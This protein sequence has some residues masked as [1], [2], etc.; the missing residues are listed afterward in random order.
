[1]TYPFCIIQKSNKRNTFK[2]TYQILKEIAEV[3]D[4]LTDQKQSRVSELLG[5]KLGLNVVQS[6]LGNF[7]T[8]KQIVEELDEGLAD[9]SASKELEKSLDS[10]QAKLNQLKSTWQQF[11][12]D[13]LDTG[14]VKGFVDALKGLVSAL[15]TVVKVA[16]KY[17][18]AAK[19]FGAGIFANFISKKQTGGLLFGGANGGVLGRTFLPGIQSQ[20]LMDYTQLTQQLGRA[21]IA[22]KQ[23][24]NLDELTGINQQLK[25]YVKNTD[26]ASVSVAGFYASQTKS[27]KGFLGSI[28]AIRTYNSISSNNIIQRK[29]F[30]KAVA[31]SNKQ[32]GQE[33]QNLNGANAGLST[34]TSSLGGLV[35][36]QAAAT[37]GAIAFNLAISA[38]IGLAIQGI[39]KLAHRYEEMQEKNAE[40]IKSFKETSDTLEEERNNIEDLLSQY[41]NILVT[42]S[43]LSSAQNQLIEIQENLTDA[44][45]GEIEGLD[46]L[47]NSFAE[48]IALIQKKRREDA[49]S[50]IQNKKNENDYNEAKKLLDEVAIAHWE[51]SLNG[52]ILRKQGNYTEITATGWGDWDDDKAASKIING[53]KNVDYSQYRNKLYVEGTIEQQLET[54]NGIYKQLS[55]LWGDKELD[56]NQRAWLKL[57]HD[58]INELNNAIEESKRIISEWEIKQAIADSTD[59]SPETIRNIDKIKEAIA[60][61]QQA[62]TSSDIITASEQYQALK[63]SIYAAIPEEDEETRGLVD[64]YFEEIEKNIDQSI[65]NIRDKGKVYEQ[66]LKK[67]QDETYSA[68]SDGITKI[69]N[70]L[71]TVSLG[72][73]IDS[74]TLL[75]LAKNDS[76]L[77]GEF[78]KTADGYTLSIEALNKARKKLIEE[79][80][81]DVEDEIESNKKFIEDQKSL[82]EFYTKYDT[83]GFLIN[84]KER[85]QAEED[86]KDAEERLAYWEAYLDLIT[87]ATDA[88]SMFQQ[89]MSDIKG[90]KDN[91]TALYSDEGI[92]D[93]FFI[94]HPE[95][96]QYKDDVEAL[97]DE[98]EKIAHTNTSPVI[99]QLQQAIK[100]A[101]DVGD[102]ESVIRYTSMLEQLTSESEFGNL[103]TLEAQKKELREQIKQKEL[104]IKGL[105]RQK[106]KEEK[107]LDSLNKQKE[108][109]E[110]IA[111]DYETAAKTAQDYIDDQIEALDKEIDKLEEHKKAI[112]DDFDA[113]I[114]AI[115]DAIDAIEKE[116]DALEK[117][118]EMQER[119]NDL[120]EKE[121]ALEK[122]RNQKVRVYTAEKGWVSK[123]ALQYS[124][125]LINK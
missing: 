28:Q 75:E 29:K 33:L 46:L 18:A 13:S 3:Y 108:A 52:Q 76:S 40:L 43:D 10:I 78:T 27:A 81:A 102:L 85:E 57:I 82:I 87:Q 68:F 60:L 123:I 39:S 111:S 11:S 62:N 53:Y 17:S 116:S 100:E 125:V 69:D 79:Q 89:A 120:K 16:N 41:S 83:N 59:L 93:Q 22:K 56:A 71:K 45:G 90:Y 98:I 105:E 8:A 64:S 65:L 112:E 61:L 121:L 9:N 77:L 36:K 55:E 92:G 66:T 104:Y 7:E 99:E 24:A 119:L 14:T 110:S 122:A 54:L 35:I 32:L 49:K 86:K 34:Y 12:T 70:A 88:T 15:D 72:G 106:S 117:E 73:S 58:R 113:R 42:T 114:Q 44:L 124:N 96:L 31:I 48:N 47:N 2:S 101:Q 4:T 20:S 118:A 109:L 38:A 30:A 94:D 37:A 97:A 26:D 74:S 63:D 91:I 19:V 95:L 80:K 21:M 107:I 23:G 50:Y 103:R 5:G 1:M 67:F 25:E 51:Q 6:I 115:K 84:S